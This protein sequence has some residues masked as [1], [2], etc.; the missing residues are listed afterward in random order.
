MT[1]HTEAAFTGEEVGDLVI[2][3]DEVGD[4]VMGRWIELGWLR[5]R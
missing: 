5:V 1:E 2:T 4:L 3:G